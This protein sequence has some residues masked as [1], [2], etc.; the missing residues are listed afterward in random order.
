MVQYKNNNN[1]CFISGKPEDFHVAV[2]VKALFIV[3]TVPADEKLNIMEYMWILQNNFES[4][5]RH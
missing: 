1:F 4:L 2:Q 3:P 5:L